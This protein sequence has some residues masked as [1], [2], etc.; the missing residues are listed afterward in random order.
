[1]SLSGVSILVRSVLPAVM[2]TILSVVLVA[3]FRNITSWDIYYRPQPVRDVTLGV[4]KALLHVRRVLVGIPLQSRSQPIDS[5]A[6][7]QCYNDDGTP[8]R[9]ST[10][11]SSELDT[12]GHRRYYGVSGDSDPRADAVGSVGDNVGG[13][14]GIAKSSMESAGFMPQK[15]MAGARANEVDALLSAHDRN[16]DWQDLEALEYWMWAWATGGPSGPGGDTLHRRD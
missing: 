9:T 11:S 12:G 3:P 15:T 16:P 14:G 13:N 1:M 5:P 7:I 6:R 2:S 8:N 4:W 10:S